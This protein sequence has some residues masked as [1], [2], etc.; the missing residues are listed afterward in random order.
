MIKRIK[1]YMLIVLCFAIL[2]C[3]STSP[4]HFFDQV[5][6]NTNYIV[7][8]APERFGKELE[9]QTIE[10]PDIPASKKKGDEAQNVVQNKVIAIERALENIKALR[11]GDD[12]MKML[13][14]NSIELFET[15]LPVY[16]KEYMEYAR[17]CD[18]KEPSSQKEAILHAIDSIYLPKVAEL[19]E[20][21][22]Q[23]GKNY[24]DKH[25][26]DVKWGR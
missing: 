16:K 9:A 12:E 26:I 20:N 1:Y 15:V 21:V 8:F 7:D 10:Y 19:M 17:L 6:L 22:Y 11:A 13:K 2:S 18:S 24:A 23:K 14:E 5:V 3:Q 4:E 25:H